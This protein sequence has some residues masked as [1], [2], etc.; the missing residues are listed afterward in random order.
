MNETP[1]DRREKRR[2]PLYQSRRRY[3]RVFLDVDWF[4]ESAGCAT[5]GR[6]LEISPRGALLLIERTG[7]FAASL[8]TLHV[9]LAG[10]A[11]MFKALGT[12][13]AR[14]GG[15]KG[16]VIRFTQVSAEDLTLLGQALIEE[17][18]LGALPGLDRKYQRFTALHRR[19]LRTSI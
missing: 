2:E 9:C 8:V 11:R 13:T 4:V 7:D 19:F 17:Y 5:L 10:R 3:P 15:P 16:W 1:I 18:G 12:A 6:G 14:S